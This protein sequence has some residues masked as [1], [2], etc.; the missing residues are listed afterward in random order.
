MAPTA[1]KD[2]MHRLQVRLGPNGRARLERVQKATDARSFAQVTED[3]V[4][5]YCKLVEALQEGKVLIL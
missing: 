4:R 3:A 2:D 5:V 1:K